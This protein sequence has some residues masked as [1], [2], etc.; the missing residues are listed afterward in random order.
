[1]QRLLN[2]FFHDAWERDKFLMRHARAI[3]RFLNPIG[4]D[5]CPSCGHLSSGNRTLPNGD[6]LPLDCGTTAEP[7]GYA[8]AIPP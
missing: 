2:P 5:V 3:N 4:K 7:H 1:M 8:S 6:V